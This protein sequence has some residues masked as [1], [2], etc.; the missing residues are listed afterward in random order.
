MLSK[1]TFAPLL[2][3]NNFGSWCINRRYSHHYML[4]CSLFC[5]TILWLKWP[6]FY[7]RINQYLFQ[8]LNIR[9]WR[10]DSQHFILAHTFSNNISIETHTKDWLKT[11]ML[12]YGFYMNCPLNWVN[13]E[14]IVNILCYLSTRVTLIYNEIFYKEYGQHL[15]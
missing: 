14:E 11:F 6:T 5:S 15:C 12:A 9:W 7:A 13:M 1:I 4:V 10:I 8:G 2:M 3:L